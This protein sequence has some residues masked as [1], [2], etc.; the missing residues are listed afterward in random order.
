[1]NIRNSDTK[2]WINLPHIFN[3]LFNKNNFILKHNESIRLDWKSLEDL[4]NNKENLSYLGKIIIIKLKKLLE[5]ESDSDF[6]FL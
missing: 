1:M 3:K 2:Q 6:T 5:I 4:D